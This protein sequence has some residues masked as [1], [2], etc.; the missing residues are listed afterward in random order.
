VSKYNGIVFSRLIVL[1]QIIF[2]PTYFSF[3]SYYWRSNHTIY[4]ENLINTFPQINIP[5][6]LVWFEINL[7]IPLFF[8]LPWL[9]FLTLNATRIADSYDLMGRAV[10][11]VR[12]DQ[13]LFY[14]TNALLTLIF[15]ILPFISPLITIIAILWYTRLFFRKILIGKISS[16]VWFIPSLIISSFP[17]LITMA[18]YS[19]YILL[20]QEIFEIWRDY[21]PFIFGIGL[22]LAISIAL[23]NFLY[24]LFEGRKDLGTGDSIPI[25][26]IH[27]FKTSL[28]VLLF[29]VF[30]QREAIFETPDLINNLNYLALTLGITEFIIRKIRKMDTN[31]YGSGII[32]IAAFSIL[33]LLLNLINN[34]ITLVHLLQSFVI[35]LSS[36]IFLTLFL[37]SFYYAPKEF[38]YSSEITNE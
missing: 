6:Q 21:T 5:D 28:F 12:I 10:G 31:N 30:Q 18:F 14:G 23:G 36:F 8:S 37:L 24:F 29:L 17:I 2:I 19:N 9:L 11:K 22:S 26:F 25:N 35:I 38:N 20:F 4:F 13:K 32:M 16:L 7:G 15:L 34:D 33:N 1:A 3:F 27:L